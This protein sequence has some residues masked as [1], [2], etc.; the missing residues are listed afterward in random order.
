[1]LKFRLINIFNNQDIKGFGSYMQIKTL[2]AIHKL[3]G[4]IR[5]LALHIVMRMNLVVC[6][7]S[8]GDSSPVGSRLNGLG[9]VASAAEH[10]GDHE[11]S[12]DLRAAEAVNVEV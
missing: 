10:E 12:P 6:A 1:M 9:E 11:G 3:A 5:I 4:L 8:V 2:I 7:V